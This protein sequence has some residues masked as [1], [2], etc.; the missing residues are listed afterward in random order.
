MLPERLA[1]GPDRR[2]Q[3]EHDGR[4]RR[5]PGRIASP[6]AEEQD[7]RRQRGEERGRDLPRQ[8][9]ARLVENEEASRRREHRGGEHRRE[10]GVD[11]DAVRALRPGEGRLDLGVLV[12]VEVALLHE[13]GR[14]PL[15]G[16]RVPG[17]DGPAVGQEQHEQDGGKAE[18]GPEGGAARQGTRHP[19]DVA[20]VGTDAHQEGAFMRER[21]A[22][23]GRASAGSGRPRARAR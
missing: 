9:R 23:A 17:A 5:V 13:A 22:T 11:R 7:P 6:E 18:S 16:P 8:G 1:R 14:H 3:G 4:P 21:S 19:R 12:Q 10:D 15:G 2:S 20:L